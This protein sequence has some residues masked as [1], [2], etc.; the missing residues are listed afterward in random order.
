MGLLNQR[1]IINPMPQLSQDQ[2]IK[3]LFNYQT[4]FKYNGTL[5]FEDYDD[6]G[7]L[8]VIE[9]QGVRSL[10]FGT[11][12]RQSAMLIQEPY[13][14]YLD[15][16]RTM[17]AWLLFKDTL[18]HQ[19]ALLIGLGGGSIAKHLL[20]TFPDCQIKAVE[21]RRGVVKVAR[22]HFGLPLDSRLKVI[23]DDGAGYVKKRQDTERNHYSLIMIDAFDHA[24]M[25][26]SI[27]NWA[28]FD[29]CHQLLNKEGILAINLWGGV[30]RPQFQQVAL[31]LGQLFD[32]KVLFLPVKGR[33]NIIGFAFRDDES[34]PYVFK[35][36]R[37]RAIQ[38][39]ETHQIEF[40]HF[41]KEIIAHN[42]SVLHR[43]IVSH[44]T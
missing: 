26:E 25:A 39:Q 17:S 9:S 30:R 8:E 12:P 6:E 37:K 28:F 27:C 41:L 40:P 15:Y 20:H 29:H 22:S 35:T 14:L 4:P 23:I 32:W 24:G 44:A 21:Y 33:G 43:V 3:Q 11:L 31:W 5:V 36:L 42:A 13:R 34:P 7:I 16:A 10:H 18:N 19:E 1:Q 38:L 2:K